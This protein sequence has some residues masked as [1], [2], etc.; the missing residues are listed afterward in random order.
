MFRGI[1]FPLLGPTYRKVAG[2]TKSLRHHG[3]FSISQTRVCEH[4]L[5]STLP[6]MS[7]LTKEVWER[8]FLKR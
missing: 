4:A 1:A 7:S 2:R 8:C 6:G 5:E 3:S